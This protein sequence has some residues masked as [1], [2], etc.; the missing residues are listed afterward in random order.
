M[1]ENRPNAI[2]GRL[3]VSREDFVVATL[4][5][6]S[7]ER[8]EVL[9]DTNERAFD[10]NDA[11]PA[12]DYGLKQEIKRHPEMN[13]NNARPWRAYAAAALWKHFAETKETPIRRLA[14]AANS[15]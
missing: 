10:D 9:G 11:F 15:A 14:R 4:G 12:T 7:R 5:R 2:V 3:I 1:V 6:K 8:A 13:V